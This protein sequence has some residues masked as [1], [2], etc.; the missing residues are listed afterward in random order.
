MRWV[1]SKALSDA[2][3][4]VRS[5]MSFVVHVTGIRGIDFPAFATKAELIS[6]APNRPQET[7][8]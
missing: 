2:V 1:V 5:H 6:P 3:R 8:S 7:V 4:R